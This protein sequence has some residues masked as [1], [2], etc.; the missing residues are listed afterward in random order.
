MT[1]HETG[2]VIP[3]ASVQ[4]DD[5][6]ACHAAAVRTSAEIVHPLTAEPWGSPLLRPRA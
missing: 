5:V 4:V 2:P 1:H 6:D 3:A